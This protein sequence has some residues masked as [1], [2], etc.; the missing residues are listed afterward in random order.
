ME[1]SGDFALSYD[2]MNY[3]V[4]HPSITF[5]YHVTYE[6][7][8]YTIII[9]AG[10]AFSSP[11]IKWYGPLWLLANYGNGKVPQAQKGINE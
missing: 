9:P 6:D 3:L 11:E 7:V 4:E 2:I 1:Y 10:K 5:V 8:E